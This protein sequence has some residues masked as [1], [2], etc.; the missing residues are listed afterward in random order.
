MNSLCCRAATVTGVKTFINHTFSKCRIN[1]RRGTLAHS[2]VLNSSPCPFLLS[3]L[4]NCER[5]E[6]RVSVLIIICIS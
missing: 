1:D 4:E 2:S 6:I 3:G 5:H